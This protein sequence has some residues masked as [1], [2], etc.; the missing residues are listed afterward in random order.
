MVVICAAR[1]KPDS[2]QSVRMWMIRIWAGAQARCGWSPRSGARSVNA[3]VKPSSQ[4][5]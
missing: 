5:L 2:A 4:N 1:L 3:P